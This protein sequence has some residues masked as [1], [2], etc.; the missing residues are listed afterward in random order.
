MGLSGGTRFVPDAYSR[1][2]P[3]IVVVTTPPTFVL[4]AFAELGVGGSI[5]LV[6]CERSFAM[7]GCR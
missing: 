7:R 1:A 4:Q 6:D 5:V 2:M 3:R